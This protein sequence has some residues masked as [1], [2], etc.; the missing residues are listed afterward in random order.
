ML[1]G[2]GPAH[3][4][5]LIDRKAEPER[6]LLNGRGRGFSATAARPVG[7][8]DH[9][10]DFVA[11]LDYPLQRRNGERRGP[12]KY[13]AHRRRPTPTRRCAGVS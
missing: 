9:R 8:G 12:E 5:G 2:F 3:A 7:L 6:R 11:R 13:Q 1:D 10:H 4:L